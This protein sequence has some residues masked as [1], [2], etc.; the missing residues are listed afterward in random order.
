MVDCKICKARYIG[1]TSQKFLDRADQH[2]RC[3][4]KQNRKN[5]FYMHIRKS[6]GRKHKIKGCE[7]MDWEG[8]VFLDSERYW[9]K[10]KIKESLYINAYDASNRLKGLM[11]LEKGCKIDPCW[12]MFNDVIKE[13]ISRKTKVV[14]KQE[15]SVWSKRLRPRP[16]LELVNKNK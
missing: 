7:S 2:Q 6:L 4:R 16:R 9:K 1:E 8:T 13:H 3:I 11:N 5:G 12:N 15:V 14:K 10:R